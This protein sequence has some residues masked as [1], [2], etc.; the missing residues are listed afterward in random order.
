MKVGVTANVVLRENMFAFISGEL[1]SSD[2]ESTVLESE[3]RI[4]FRLRGLPV[5]KGAVDRSQEM[6]ADMFAFSVHIQVLTVLPEM[7]QR[8]FH[9]LGRGSRRLDYDRSFTVVDPGLA[10]LSFETG[11]V[12]RHAGSSWDR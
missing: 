2:A 4:L 6:V 1:S 11:E 8:Q 9:S 5:R 12:L 3:V 10:E 7:R